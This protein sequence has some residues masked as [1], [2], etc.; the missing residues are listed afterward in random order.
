MT[1]TLDVALIQTRTPATAEAA[2]TH[3]APLV[4]QAAADG[5]AACRYQDLGGKNGEG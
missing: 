3:V 2:L 5:A 4:R 1:D